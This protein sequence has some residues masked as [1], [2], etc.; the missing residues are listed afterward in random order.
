MNEP[1]AS[2]GETQWKISLALASL[3]LDSD[4]SLITERAHTGRSQGLYDHKLTST[5][6]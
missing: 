5:V 2:V 4:R 3:F 1:G 6:A